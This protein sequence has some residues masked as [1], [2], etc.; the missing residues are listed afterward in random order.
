MIKR[1]YTILSKIVFFKNIRF[2][3][4]NMGQQHHSNITSLQQVEKPRG[5]PP[6]VVQTFEGNFS[7]II[8]KTA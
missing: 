2:S 5:H 3:S 4:T 6:V 8:A 7:K 1:N